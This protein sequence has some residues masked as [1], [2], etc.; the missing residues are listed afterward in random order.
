MHAGSPL[1]KPEDS[2]PGL[3][4]PQTGFR[5]DS[6]LDFNPGKDF[7]TPGNPMTRLQHW[8]NYE[9]VMRCLIRR[10]SVPPDSLIAQ[11]IYS[12]VFSACL[13]SETHIAASEERTPRRSRSRGSKLC[14]LQSRKR[15]WRRLWSAMERCQRYRN[16][17][18]C[19]EEARPVFVRQLFSTPPQVE[20][21]YL[22]ASGERIQHALP[23]ACQAY[24]TSDE[25]SKC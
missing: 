19:K 9:T 4:F 1:V 17:S 3:T 23:E 24:V 22:P 10:S 20:G 11:L 21:Q 16:I 12:A 15:S 14:C 25:S 18:S 5:L 7:L 13:R 6:H 2:G 8:S